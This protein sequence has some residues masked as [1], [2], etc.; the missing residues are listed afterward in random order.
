MKKICVSII[1]LLFISFS[2]KAQQ[3]TLDSWSVGVNAGL[4][5]VG[6]QGATSLFP[7]LKLRGPAT[8]ILTLHNRMWQSSR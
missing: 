8:I 6:V 2:G 5:G 3:G 7:N 1:I 4:Y